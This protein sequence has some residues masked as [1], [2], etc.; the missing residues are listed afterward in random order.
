MNTINEF[1]QAILKG[2]I[3]PVIKALED[4]D[5]STTKKECLDSILGRHEQLKQKI[6]NGI[7]SHDNQKLDENQIRKDLLS[8]ISDLENNNVQKNEFIIKYISAT[9][10]TEK[11]LWKPYSND[12]YAFLQLF[13]NSNRIIRALNFI[14]RNIIL[15]KSLFPIFNFTFRNNYHQD[16]IFVKIKLRMTSLNS[17]IHG[18]PDTKTHILKPVALQEW[19]IL[20]GD[21]ILALPAPISVAPKSAFMFQVKLSERSINKYDARKYLI[22]GKR[23]LDFSFQFENDIIITTPTLYLNCKNERD[24]NRVQIAR[25][26]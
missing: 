13:D 1:R 19:S 16:V 25:L 15:S 5:L 14:G 22:D 18:I 26:S 12:E 17:G 4:I 8:F 9:I 6:M 23:A 21:N 3:K 20:E 24:G 11:S 7:I 2:K 10:D